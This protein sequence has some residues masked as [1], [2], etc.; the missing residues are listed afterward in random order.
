MHRRAELSINLIVIVVIALLIL[1]IIV[2]I[3]SDNF[4][5]FM[6]STECVAANGQCTTERNCENVLSRDLCGPFHVCCSVI[7]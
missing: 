7:D 6:R 1:V 4:G 3:L 5:N 2:F